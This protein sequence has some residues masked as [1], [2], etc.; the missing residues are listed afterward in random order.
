MTV[1]HPDN[2]CRCV[3]FESDVVTYA[4]SDWDGVDDL[5]DLGI[6]LRLE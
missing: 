4:K 6:V 3:G 5:E 2:F 1:M